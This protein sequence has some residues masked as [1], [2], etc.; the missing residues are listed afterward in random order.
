MRFGR[1]V[2]YWALAGLLI[3]VGIIVGF[4]IVV[5]FFS[6]D[7]GGGAVVI[8]AV[9]RLFLWPTQMMFIGFHGSPAHEILLVNVVA[10]ILNVALYCVVGSVVWCI[11]RVTLSIRS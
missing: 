1:F 4:W 9:L 2:A 8:L 7:V 10:I 3:P 11:R 5:S 6:P